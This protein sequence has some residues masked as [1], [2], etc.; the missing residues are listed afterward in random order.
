MRRNMISLTTN[1]ALVHIPLMLLHKI[2]HISAVALEVL[3]IGDEY[4]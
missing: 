4:M 3:S 1:Y 2:T